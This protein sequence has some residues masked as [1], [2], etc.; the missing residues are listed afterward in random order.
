M[1]RLECVTIYRYTYFLAV[2]DSNPVILSAK[3]H[4]PSTF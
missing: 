1:F 2:D 4:N 3:G